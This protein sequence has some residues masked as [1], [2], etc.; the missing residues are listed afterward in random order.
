MKVILNATRLSWSKIFN[1]LERQDN[2]I[3]AKITY[4]L[5]VNDRQ[6]PCVATARFNEGEV[7]IGIGVSFE[8][9]RE[10]IM[11]KLAAIAQLPTPPQPEEVDI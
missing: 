11:G 10:R 8:K 5:D 9:A 4:S 2:Q 7:I 3:K 1:Q 6:N